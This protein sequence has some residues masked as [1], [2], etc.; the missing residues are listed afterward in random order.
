MPAV[1][2]GKHEGRPAR[3]QANEL[4]AVLAAGKLHVD[5]DDVDRQRCQ[6][7]A[8]LDDARYRTDHVGQ[9]RRLD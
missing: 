4:E 2:G 8:R 9:A 3:Q 6:R 7:L 1:G 5:E